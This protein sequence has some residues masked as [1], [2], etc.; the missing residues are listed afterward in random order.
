LKTL[1]VLSD[2]IWKRQPEER[3][4]PSMTSDEAEKWLNSDH[5][6]SIL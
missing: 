4:F 2:A 3:P 6:G 5:Q 1:K